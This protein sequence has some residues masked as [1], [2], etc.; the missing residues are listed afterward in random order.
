MI[1]CDSTV[2][3]G[4]QEG[5][6]TMKNYKSVGASLYS[7][8]STWSF[9]ALNH[10]TSWTHITTKVIGYIYKKK[11]IG[12]TGAFLKKKFALSTFYAFSQET[13]SVIL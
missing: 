4:T 10:I 12:Y 9:P 2:E 13:N 8:L 7:L 3:L 1:H 11:D 5:S 6:T